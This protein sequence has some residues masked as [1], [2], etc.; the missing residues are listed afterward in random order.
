MSAGSV[1]TPPTGL[2][3]STFDTVWSASATATSSLVPDPF[4]IAINGHDYLHDLEFKPWKRQAMRA[5]TTTVTRTQADTSNE[6][7]EQSLSTESLWRRTQDSWQLGAGQVYL[8]RKGSSEFSFRQSKGVNPWVQWQLTLLNDT[9]LGLASANTNLGMVV[10][11]GHV[12]VCD[13][14][15]LKFSSNFTSWTTVTGTPSDTASSICTDGFNVYVAYGAG[16][17]YTTTEGAS[18]AT[19]LVTSALTSSAVVRFVMGRLMVA[20]S[21]NLYNIT[22]TSPAVLPTALLQSTYG[23]IVWVDLTAG[24]GAIFAAG[25]SGNVGVLYSIQI[26]TDGTA[27]A[28]PIVCGQLPYGETVNAIY[29]YAGSGMAIGTNLGF[30]FAE[31]TLA[32]SISLTVA[33][34]I[35]PLFNQTSGFDSS[36]NAFAAYSRFIYGTWNDYDTGSTG[37]FRMDPSQFVSDLAPA[38]ASD[39]M[40]ATQGNVNAIA[41]MANGTVLFTVSGVGV[42]YQTTTYV[43]SGTIDSGFITYG[44]ADNKMPVFVDVATLMLEGSIQTEVSLDSRAFTPVGVA[45]EPNSIYNEFMTP[46]QLA[47][48]IEIREILTA[49]AGQTTTPTLT[50][51]TLRAA[52]ATV[53]PTDWSVVIQLR[54]TVRIKDVEIS[55]VPSVEY[56][57]LDGLRAGKTICTLQVGNIGPMTVTI[58][59]IDWIPEQWASLSGELNGVA[60]LTCRTV[61]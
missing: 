34:N 24:T 42:Y 57:F 26:E 50:R 21:N 33:L 32:N 29:G 14:Q 8:D 7:G 16:G 36:C 23:D 47:N 28:G 20:N 55:L 18:A 40:A 60:V 6:P 56:Q 45:Q 2:F 4:V 37:L 3:D 52:P 46:Q 51:H 39:L 30:R 41:V 13:G 49:G 27:L 10:C 31:Q 58:E 54:E 12:Y 43:A 61:V 22:S 11:G 38:F 15:A 44:L 59:G 5:T 25:N 48:T 17:L 35:G 1:I 9:A 53:A 19:Q